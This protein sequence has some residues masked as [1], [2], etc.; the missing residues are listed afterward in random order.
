MTT[1]GVQYAWFLNEKTESSKTL[2]GLEIG[3]TKSSLY[4][5]ENPLFF[6]RERNSTAEKE[7]QVLALEGLQALQMIY[8]FAIVDFNYHKI[9]F[10]QKLSKTI[11]AIATD[12]LNFSKKMV[13]TWNDEKQQRYQ[14]FLTEFNNISKWL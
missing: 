8:G 4:P 10:Q 12:A 7:M 2:I 11:L 1:V 13:D 5:A 14:Y 6:W 3:L 9:L